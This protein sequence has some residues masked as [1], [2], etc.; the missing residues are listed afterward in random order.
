MG[1]DA[2]AHAPLFT[3]QYYLDPT[4]TTPVKQS[5]TPLI[6][7]DLNTEKGTNVPDST[8]KMPE[9]HWSV[10]WTGTIVAPQTGDYTFTADGDNRVKVIVDGHTIIDKT[11]APRSAVTGSAPLNAGQAVPVQVDY[12]H[13]TGPSSLH[14]DWEGP[15]VDKQAL[16]PAAR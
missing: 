8:V 9:E 16:T 10:R 2:L 12:V 15:G 1:P 5:V 7:F 11:E 14:I 3:V 4:F 6:D 13:D